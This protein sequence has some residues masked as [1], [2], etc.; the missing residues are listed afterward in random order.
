MS[1]VRLVIRDILSRG[2][3][4]LI[5]MA[6]LQFLFALTFIGMA[7]P[8]ARYLMLPLMFLGL[9]PILAPN[10]RLLQCLP[11]TSNAIDRMQW[12]F[13]GGLVVI[14]AT[15]A[16]L[17]AWLS[18]A[19]LLP[20]QDDIA[21]LKVVTLILGTPSLISLFMLLRRWTSYGVDPMHQNRPILL[22]NYFWPALLTLALQLIQISHSGPV[23]VIVFV[24]VAMGLGVQAIFLIAPRRYCDWIAKPASRTSKIPLTKRRLVNPIGKQLLWTS[25]IGG[26]VAIFFAW[27]AP[28]DEMRADIGTTIAVIPMAFGFAL[29]SA[30]KVIRSLPRTLSQSALN[31]MMIFLVP[32]FITL[33]IYAAAC[34]AFGSQVTAIT[35]WNALPLIAAIAPFAPISIRVAGQIRIRLVLFYLI[36]A[37]AASWVGKR[38]GLLPY[39]YVVLI[40]LVAV[41]TILGAYF[42]M[43]HE[44]RVG[45]ALYRYRTASPW[46][47]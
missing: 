40:N 6:V 34:S 44:L 39:D 30:L 23:A 33:L 47:G 13:G 3:W 27:L 46:T 38:I 43:R 26:A 1:P 9:V 18:A 5:A 35:A 36:F 24:I 19:I 10:R 37:V 17:L 25:A 21:Y 22:V 2:K 32:S 15:T 16:T 20:R 31:L 42:W 11:L 8:Y 14:I 7:I 45:T 28:N 4:A 41:A 12:L 29:L